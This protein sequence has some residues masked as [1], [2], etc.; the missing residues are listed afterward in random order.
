M[1]HAVTIVVPGDLH[2]SEPDLPNHRTALWMT[3]QVNTLIRPDFVQFIGDNV[4]DATLEQ[5]RLFRELTERLQVPW[6][7]LVGDHDSHSDPLA[8][9]FR[10][11]VGDPTGVLTLRGFSF[12]RLNTREALPVGLSASQVDWF[13]AVADAASTDGKRLVVFQHN[14][15]YQIWEDFAGPGIDAWREIV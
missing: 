3:E 8:G 5:F 7:A 10:E 13:R 4:Q 15:P 12:V 1:T 14:Y 9:R 6:F 2:L 11:W